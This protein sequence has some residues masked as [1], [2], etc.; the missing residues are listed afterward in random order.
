MSVTARYGDPAAVLGVGN[1]VLTL[2]LARR[3]VRRFA[4]RDVTDDELSALVAAAQSAP[5]SSNLQPWSV[6]AVRDPDRKKRLAMSS[7]GERPMQPLKEWKAK[8]LLKMLYLLTDGARSHRQ[9]VGGAFEAEMVARRL[10]GSKPVERRQ[11]IAH[12]V[13]R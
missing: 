4:P 6:V 10:E 8:H 1:D 5:T 3:S 7:Q 2:Q 9:F 11:S 12:A 13:P